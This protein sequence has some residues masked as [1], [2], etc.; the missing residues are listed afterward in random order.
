MRIKFLAFLLLLPVLA[1]AQVSFIP[2][3]NPVKIGDGINISVPEFDP[4]AI[5]FFARAGVT[6]AT[7]K[8]QISDFVK[9]VKALGLW[10]NMVCWPLRSTQNAGTGS[11]AYSLGGLGTYNGTLVNGPTWGTTGITIPTVGGAGMSISS[12]TPSSFIYVGTNRAS[13]GNDTYANNALVLQASTNILSLRKTSD[14]TIILDSTV[15]ASTTVYNF[16]GVRIAT[17]D[18]QLTV[19]GV[20]YGTDVSY[21]SFGA[22]TLLGVITST[23]SFFAIGNTGFSQAQLFALHSLYKSTLGAGLGMP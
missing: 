22:A 18:A 23:A 3:G 9:G 13:G 14:G 5:A 19:N 20:S 12:L 16:I 21:N 17:N 6:N 10:S 11:T 7:G 8:R 1:L 15:A 2:P 4:D